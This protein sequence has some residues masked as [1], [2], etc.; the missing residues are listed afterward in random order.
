MIQQN[1]SALQNFNT[2]KDQ[3]EEPVSTNLDDMLGNLQE[4]ME[5][6]GVKITQKGLCAC[7]DKPIVG[8]VVTALGKTFRPECF[9]CAQCNMVR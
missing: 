4:N 8:Q 7:C 9:T 3:K 6:Q 5:K 2:F 1:N